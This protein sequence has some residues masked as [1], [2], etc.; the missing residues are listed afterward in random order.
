MK[1]IKMKKMRKFFFLNLIAVF[2]F[3]ML[4]AQSKSIDMSAMEQVWK[5]IAKLEKDL[6][7]SEEEWKALFET[8]AYK[9]LGDW[10]NENIRKNFELV[11][12]PAKR[13]EL[14]TV[15][16]TTHYWTKR[17]LNHLVKVREQQDEIKKY[18]TRVDVD[19]ILA[20]ALKRAEVYLPK[21][22]S[23]KYPPPPIRFLIFSPDARSNN[24]NIIYDLQLARNQGEN[25]FTNVIG[26]EA[27]HHYSF[28]IEKTKFNYPD[29]SSSY[30]PILS[31]IS[32]LCWEGI[33][34]LIDKSYPPVIVNNDT[35][36]Y[37]LKINAQRLQTA[38]MKTLDSMLCKMSDDTTG[39]YEMGK[40][41][42]SL[43]PG[44]AHYNGQYMAVL[45][46]KNLGAAPLVEAS[47]NPFLFFRLYQKACK[48]EKTEYVLSNKAMTFINKMEKMFTVKNK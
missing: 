18:Q 24:G 4:H 11:F 35:A 28:M 40:S 32:H 34:D 44:N 46:K 33:A 26:H 30:D 13:A 8:P 43:F 38:K 17:D 37:N 19:K 2:S 9:A 39:I 29:E 36:G 6:K 1:K 31:A 25:E 3:N 23:K 16:R 12:P 15:L 14:D 7:P 47:S 45:I 21:G 48:Q 41:A 22:I 20:E 10:N 27:H 5:V 42:L